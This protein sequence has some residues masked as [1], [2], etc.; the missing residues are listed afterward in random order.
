VR[1]H[2]PSRLL[3]LTYTTLSSQDLTSIV[4]K[5][6]RLATCQQNGAFGF[7]RIRTGQTQSS[8]V[9]RPDFYGLTKPF[10][11][12]LRADSNDCMN[13]TCDRIPRSNNE[14]IAMSVRDRLAAKRTLRARHWRDA[15]EYLAII[16]SKRRQVTRSIAVAAAVIYPVSRPLNVETKYLSV[17]NCSR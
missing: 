10:G 9:V 3:T 15:D 4:P 12:T 11:L 14:R 8:F 6:V 1:L 16:V 2:R 17:E 13:C 7:A 5:R